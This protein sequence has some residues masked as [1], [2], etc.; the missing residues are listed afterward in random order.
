MWHLAKFKI[1]R[2][3]TTAECRAP[4]GVNVLLSEVSGVRACPGRTAHRE[5]D[6]RR[7]SRVLSDG[8]AEQRLDVRVPWRLP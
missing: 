3:K 5:P 8:D 6:R 4:D 1:R 7:Q 2:T